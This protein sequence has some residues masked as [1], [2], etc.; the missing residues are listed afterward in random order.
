LT[1]TSPKSA[2][3]LRPKF[4]EMSLPLLA[5]QFKLKMKR[6]KWHLLGLV[7]KQV[8]LSFLK[9]REIPCACDISKKSTSVKLLFN[10]TQ[11]LLKDSGQN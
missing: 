10:Y 9:N 11:N 2:Q 8:H 7:F 3:A 5:P 4:K 1:T 6:S